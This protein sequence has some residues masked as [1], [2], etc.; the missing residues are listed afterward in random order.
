MDPRC[1]SYCFEGDGNHEKGHLFVLIL[2]LC[3]TA[4]IAVFAETAAEEAPK[5]EMTAEELFQAGKAAYDAEDYGKAIYVDAAFRLGAE[6]ALELAKR[7]KPDL[8][9]LQ[10]RSP[11]CG[12]KQVYDG[13]FSGTLIPGEGVFAQLARQAGFRVA[14]VEDV[15]DERVWRIMRYEEIMDRVLKAAD[16]SE[17]VPEDHSRVLSDLRELEAYYMSPEW[18]EDYSADEAGLLPD[19]LKRGVQSQDGIWNLL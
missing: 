19:W 9:I 13:T 15:T 6:K 3:F 12:A 7:E 18:K 4:V 1:E 10:S 2:C 17:T 11:S 5:A 16:R 14:D 8:I